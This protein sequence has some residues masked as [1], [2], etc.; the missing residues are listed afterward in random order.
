[1]TAKPKTLVEEAIP[2]AFADAMKQV[3]VLIAAGDE[4]VSVESDDLLQ[5]GDICG[6]LYS[7]DEQKFGFSF[8]CRLADNDDEALADEGGTIEWY[9]Y[10]SKNQIAEIAEGTTC[11]INMWRCSTRDCGRRWSEPDGYCPRCDFPT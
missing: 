1:M 3:A 7:A 11:R 10:L 4:K 6:G 9:F 2:D 5:I 8:C